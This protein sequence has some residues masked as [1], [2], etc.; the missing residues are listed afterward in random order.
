M[1]QFITSE[2]SATITGS[3]TMVFL[4]PAAAPSVNIAMLRMWAGQSGSTTSAQQRIRL[5][6]QVVGFPTGLTAALPAKVKRHD[7]A[8]SVLLQTNTGAAASSGTN[9]TGE[10]TGTQTPILDDAFNVLNGWLHVPTPAE[11]IVFPAGST[12]GFGMKFPTTPSS[13]VNWSFG[14][15]FEER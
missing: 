8:A 12:S 1:R 5:V 4:N 13:L 6:S 11:V 15:T 7:V 14:V 9:S 2:G 3:T 10:G